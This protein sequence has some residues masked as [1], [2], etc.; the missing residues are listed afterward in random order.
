MSIVIKKYRLYYSI[1]A[2]FDN[3]RALVTSSNG[4]TITIPENSIA[5]LKKGVVVDVCISGE[6]PFVLKFSDECINKISRDSLFT[7]EAINIP[8]TDKFSIVKSR[9]AV[10]EMI[11][12]TYFS[13]LLQSGLLVTKEHISNLEVY[14]SLAFLF[15]RFGSDIYNIIFSSAKPNVVDRVVNI[16]NSDISRK[17]KLSDISGLLYISEI[18]LRKS[19][20]EHGVSFSKILLDLRMRHALSMILNTNKNVNYISAYLGYTQPS[21][22][23]KSFKK[24]FGYTPKKIDIKIK[25]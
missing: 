9:D 12:S 15:S 6:T 21:Y 25:K 16:V 10:D 11:I 24:Y 2:F 4:D 20:D 8:S 17:W 18:S 13:N 23:I 22:F 7:Q 5:F 3:G 19:L 1:L 14:N